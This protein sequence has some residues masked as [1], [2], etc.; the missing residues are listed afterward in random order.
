MDC[1][2]KHWVGNGCTACL[3]K[4]QWSLNREMIKIS[5]NQRQVKF[6]DMNQKMARNYL[7]NENNRPKQVATGWTGRVRNIGKNR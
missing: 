7:G 2:Q 6:Q 3:T 4:G 1:K 5:I